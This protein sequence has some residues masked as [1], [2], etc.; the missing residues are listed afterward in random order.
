MDWI[1]ADPETLSKYFGEVKSIDQGDYA[2]IELQVQGAKLLHPSTG[3]PLH[4]LKLFPVK[5]HVLEAPNRPPMGNV[6]GRESKPLINSNSR[7]IN[8][9]AQ[10]TYSSP[11]MKNP[12]IA[13]VSPPSAI[14]LPTG[15][16]GAGGIGVSVPSAEKPRVKFPLQVPFDFVAANV[17]EPPAGGYLRVESSGEWVTYDVNGKIVPKPDDVAQRIDFKRGRVPAPPSDG[18]M[19]IAWRGIWTISRTADWSM[20]ESFNGTAGEPGAADPPIIA[21]GVTAP[22]PPKGG[23][24]TVDKEGTFRVYDQGGKLV[25]PQP[26]GVAATTYVLGAKQLG[27]ADLPIQGEVR[28]YPPRFSE[29]GES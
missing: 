23:W 13:S 25:N 20:I 4:D 1:E 2:I 5:K 15:A 29:V 6:A 16:G 11:T 10:G 9:A 27:P 28:L 24:V 26:T 19:Q 12:A 17:P 14:T 21:A 8:P 3:Q 7:Q 18:F 22:T